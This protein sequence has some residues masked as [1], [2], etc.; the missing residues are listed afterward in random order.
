MLLQFVPLII[1]A[2]SKRLFRSRLLLFLTL[3][4]CLSTMCVVDDFASGFYGSIIDYKS[5]IVPRIRES[6]QLKVYQDTG[7]LI[8]L[9][10]HADYF[11]EFVVVNVLSVV[12]GL[13]YILVYALFI[14]VTLITL[15]S[16]LFVWGSERISGSQRRIWLP[17]LASSILI[18]WAGYNLEVS[19]S[20]ALFLLLYLIITKPHSSYSLFIS[21]ILVTVSILMASFHETLLLGAICLLAIGFAFLAGKHFSQSSPTLASR[22]ILVSSILIM[23]SARIFSASSQSYFKSYANFGVELARSVWN[24]LNGKLAFQQQPLSTLT[25][26]LN[27]V[28]R[29]LALLF[30]V[31]YLGLLILIGILSASFVISKTKKE[32][33]SLSV[34]LI[35]IAAAIMPIIAYF[36]LKTGASGPLR[37]FSSATGLASA[38]APIVI[39]TVLSLKI[40]LRKASSEAF[41]ILTPVVLI[42]LSLILVFAPFCFYRGD[43][44]SDYDVLRLP[45]NPSDKTISGNRV[46]YF[47][48]EYVPQ[49]AAIDILSPPAGWLQHYYL[50]PLEYAFGKQVLAEPL[51]LT[52][53]NRIYDN[54][55]YTAFGEPITVLG[56][57]IMSLV[58]SSNS[59][60]LL[61]ETG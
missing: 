28:D 22:P 45:G 39:L 50:L 10:F 27:P 19:F 4:V 59:V 46:Y 36:A 25:Q 54:G 47:V 32:P 58:P 40:N 20:P 1:T 7:R 16:L 15:W 35:Y 9:N 56:S 61:N 6:A 14:R 44:K 18:A 38:L 29:N 26:I 55:L 51:N 49:N 53:P 11:L 2:V 3:A 33:L 42:S 30:I 52:S 12:T 8:S 48:L 60:V 13:S 17:L 23:T 43:I 24:M 31:S 5:G 41:R 57:D 37:D 21:S 34:L